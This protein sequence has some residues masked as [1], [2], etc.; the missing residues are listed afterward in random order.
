[1]LKERVRELSAQLES[2][3][4]TVAEL[5]TENASLQRT[6]AQQHIENELLQ[7]CVDDLRS[8]NE[9]LQR[10]VVEQRDENDTLQRCIDDQRSESETLQH[11]MSVLKTQVE[12]LQRCA[13]DSRNE[14]ESLQ[15][16]ADASRTDYG[17]LERST[18]ELRNENEALKRTVDDLRNETDELSRSTAEQRAENETL[19]RRIVE[20]CDENVS[21]RSKLDKR[22]TV[23]FEE[24]V[25]TDPLHDPTQTNDYSWSQSPNTNARANDA[26][27]RPD[28]RLD[29]C[30]SVLP[31]A[32]SSIRIVNVH[33]GIQTD[34]VATRTRHAE[35]QTRTDAQTRTDTPQRN[36]NVEAI[37][38]ATSKRDA[39]TQKDDASMIDTMRRYREQLGQLVT[40][41]QALQKRVATSST[42]ASTNTNETD[43][44]R[45]LKRQIDAELGRA[46]ELDAELRTYISLRIVT[47]DEERSDHGA[48]RSAG[49]RTCKL[50]RDEPPNELQHDE[51]LPRMRAKL[52][53]ADTDLLR[54]RMFSRIAAYHARIS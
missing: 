10:S 3:Q 2:L 33:C 29:V 39:V 20:T 23:R 52:E 35:T 36:R 17:T 53:L 4:R 19:K 45:A 51:L 47:T 28:S 30:V 11:S 50:Q 14:A 46:A 32:D 21:L 6:D 49:A 38:S 24:S 54:L 16:H 41:W 22:H 15:R 5:R 12:S 44:I 8:E 31:D 27:C 7:R 18:A 42:S 25:Q 34:S 43:N 9:S 48:S 26:V 40:D 37:G 13:A 1:M